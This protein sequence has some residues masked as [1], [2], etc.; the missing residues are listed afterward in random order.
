MPRSKK[1][2]GRRVYGT[3][4]V[5]QRKGRKKHPW[6][7]TFVEEDTGKRR[8]I[9]A[10]SEKEAN[11]LLQKALYDQKHGT[12]ATGPRQTVKQYLEYWLED[13]HKV[14]IKLTSYTL[15]RRNFNKH[16]IPTVGQIQ[17][18]K[19]RPNHVQALLAK[20]Q[21]EGQSPQSIRLIHR[22][23][24]AA[25][26]DAVKWNYIS[27]NPCKG[28]ELPRNRPLEIHYLTMEQAQALLEAAKRTQLECLLAMAITTGMRKGELLALHWKDVDLE[29]RRLKVRYTV[30]P[31]TSY[32]YVETEPK[33]DSS[34]RTIM[35]PAF[36]IDVLKQHRAALLEQRLQA[37]TQWEEKGLVFPNATG[38]YTNPSTLHKHFKK[39]LKD[40]SLP[41]MR[42]HDLRHSAATLLLC[43]G[44]P[45]KVVQE[46]LGHS[47]IK[48]TM[49]V[50]S[51]VLP[52]MHQEVVDK[53]DN[54]FGKQH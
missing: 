42:F 20:K 7:A 50:Y 45:A 51:H 33:T 17:L 18:Q 11:D 3:G 22:Q 32:G 23:L 34:K 4:S 1:Q 16:I 5:Y 53:M 41:D 38:N 13:V 29:A 25:L 49:N 12:L 27:K 2:V 10:D 9:Q 39:L 52:A 28:V 35:L 8:Y 43:M 15:Y 31:L 6:V 36:V 26:N 47:D 48:M 14:A 46:I 37:G 30:M 24:N 19:L 44:I 54:L 40:A 21:Q